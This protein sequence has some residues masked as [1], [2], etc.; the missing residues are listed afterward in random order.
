G[1]PFGSTSICAGWY[2]MREA[3]RAGLT[4]ML[5]GQG[6]DEILA[7]YRASFGYRLSDLLRG[8]RVA[9]ATAELRSF[10]SVNGPRWAAVALASPHVPERVRLAARA[11]LRGTSTLAGTEL[12]HEGASSAVNGAV[13][14]DRLRRQLHL[15]LTHRG[16]P[17]LLRY[18]DR[19]SMV[20]SLEARVP[21]LDHRLVE[22]AFSLDGGELIRRGETKSVL[23]R[24]LADLLPREVR[25]RRDKLGFVT[26]EVRFLRGRLGELAQDVFAS[27][28][29]A[30][31]GFVD[32]V[33]ARK[34]LER[35]RRGELDAGFEL[36]RALNLELWA[37]RFV[38]A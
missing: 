35:H 12:R 14:P 28:S 7:G 16:L 5:D 29:F 30:Q 1:E 19:N 3:R 20:H 8:G 11:R 9:E 23:R 36:W 26:P 32:A 13:F 24:A 21:L 2:V 33:A 37:R 4:V 6:G 10:A 25:E 31:R 18:E 17:E 38:D 27:A 15:L 22:L 34:R